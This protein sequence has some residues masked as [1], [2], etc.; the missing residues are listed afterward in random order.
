MIWAGL[1]PGGLLLEGATIGLSAFVGLADLMQQGISAL[2]SGGND[3]MS[4][5]DSP[6][7]GAPGSINAGGG[8]FFSPALQRP[9]VGAARSAHAAGNDYP[10]GGPRVINQGYNVDR[11]SFT[12]PT[13]KWLRAL[14]LIWQLM[15]E[16]WGKQPGPG[17]TPEP[18]V[19]EP[20]P[21]PRERP[22][23]KP[24]VPSPEP[25]TVTPRV[26]II[27]GPAPWHPY[28]W[29]LLPPCSL[30]VCDGGPLTPRNI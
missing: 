4:G 27:P 12:G 25:P 7:S 28:P 11:V 20:V 24:S 18:P 16:P 13:L 3:G 15:Q 22:V 19:E 1:P 9:V 23:P 6:I 26:P 2:N 5:G 30:G 21:M 14:F 29:F 10:G 8:G 17:Y